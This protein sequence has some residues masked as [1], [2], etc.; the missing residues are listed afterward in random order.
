[1][2]KFLNLFL[3]GI[4]L[5]AFNSCSTDDVEGEIPIEETELVEIPDKAFGEYMLFQEIPGISSE[6]EGNET[7]Y[8]LDPDEVN[9]VSELSLSKTS[10]NV[11]TLVDAGLAT[12][13]TKITDLTGIEYFLG[14]QHLVLTS[15]DVE[16]IDLSNLVALEELEINFNLIGNLDVTNNPELTLIRY[17]GSASA[18]ENQLLSSIDLSNNTELRHLYLPNHNFTSINLSN[19]LQIDEMLDMSG[20]P[21]PDGDPDTPDIVVPAAIYD[22]LAPENRLGVISDAS[23]EVTAF[24]AASPMTISED[25]GVSTIT[26]SLNVATN[27]NVTINLNF[28]GTA[29]LDTDYSVSSQSVTIPSGETEATIDLTA[30]QDSDIEGNETVEVNLGAVT[31]AI[32]AENQEF[33]INLEDDDIEN[34]LILNEILYDPS[35]DNLDG[36]A[37]GDGTYAQNEDEFIEIYNNSSSPF[38]V[39]GYK[40]FD[41]EALDADT[42]RHVIPNGTV[43]PANS[44]I[45]IFGGGTPTGSFGGAIVQTSTTGDLNL[46]NSGDVLTIQDAE[47]TVVISFDIE[48]LS[49]NPN[50]SYTRNPDITGDFEQHGG[51]S[52][53]LFSPGTK[54]DGTSF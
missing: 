41:T 52:A 49:N 20:N 42:P 27:Q 10:S 54:T 29:T 47:G 14:L 53:T 23:V 7:K 37:N 39:S 33:T 35:N 2:N 46:N 1:M 21:G 50:E 40:I 9:V 36:D 32:A 43:I 48:P 11:Q 45:V 12:A 16:E 25:G 31:N 44:A 30:T 26:A 28:A 4:I 17:K 51:V 5:L 15:N 22:Q 8:Y 13:E 19:N 3:F 24:I 34:P 6:I 18:D 38:D